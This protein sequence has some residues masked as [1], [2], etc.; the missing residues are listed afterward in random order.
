[1]EVSMEMQAGVDLTTFVASF[2]L[3]SESS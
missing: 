1:M 3:L 2:F